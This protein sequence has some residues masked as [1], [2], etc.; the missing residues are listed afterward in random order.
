MKK[1][2]KTLALVLAIGTTA[3]ALTS[4]DADDYTYPDASWSDGIIVTVNDKVYQYSEIYDQ[5]QDSHERASAL[6]DIAQD[7]AAQLATPITEGMQVNVDD[8]ID[9]LE[10]T[11]RANADT[12]GTSYREEMENGLDDEGVEDLDELRIKYL[13]QEQISAN[14]SDFTNDQTVSTDRGNLL[15]N[16]SEEMTKDYVETQ[17]PYHISHILVNVDAASASSDMTALYDGHI[18]A[19][20]AN[21]I[22]NVVFGLSSQNSTFGDVAR[23]LSD[24]G[25]A[26]NRGELGADSSSA[27]TGSAVGLELTTSYVNEFKLGIYAY[28]ALIN[29]Q[30]S[31][32]EKED[33]ITST[34]MPNALNESDYADADDWENTELGSGKVFGIP[35]SVA[36]QMGEVADQE[37]ADDGHTVTDTTE[38]QY[39]RNILFNNYFNNHSVSFIYDDSSDYLKEDNTPNYDTLLNEINAAIDLANQSAESAT[40]HVTLEEIQDPSSAYHERLV[41]FEDLCEQ[42]TMI[43][44]SKF[45][46]TAPSGMLVTYPTTASEGTQQDDN[47]YV[48]VEGEQKILSNGENNPI[49]VVRAGADSYQ[50][51]HFITIHRD[52]FQSYTNDGKEY[53]PDDYYTYFRVNVPSTNDT[54]ATTRNYESYPSY[55]NYVLSDPNNNSTYQ[56]RID[57]VKA[58]IQAY[59]PNMNFIRFRS[60]L[61]TIQQNHPN[62]GSSWTEVGETLFGDKWVE[63]KTYMDNT[64]NSNTSSNED[65]LDQAWVEYTRL[66]N[67]QAN[68]TS[69]DS[70]RVVPTVCINYFQSGSY[71]SEELEALCHVQD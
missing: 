51:I 27:S 2:M 32:E 71:D 31:E 64:V 61:E 26:S 67:N 8:K 52:P 17:K 15:F 40:P 28:D 42:M 35:L 41:E 6:F 23:E 38:T 62:L 9:H 12:N 39:P 63:I 14:E 20:N 11:W 50:G 66:L 57:A 29:A 3:S 68:N 19:D 69:G 22:R 59:D 5:L 47:G 48:P 49:I 25:S 43:D 56:S 10:E 24:D 65:S 7:I 45:S 13:S 53:T 4:C 36:L 46:T 44:K 33:V 21:K 1:G 37:K 30:I 70:D 54:N 60:N 16:I 55:V 34:R 18:S 58:A